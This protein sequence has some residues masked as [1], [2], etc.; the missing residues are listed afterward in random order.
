MDARCTDCGSVLTV[1]VSRD[2]FRPCP[3]CGSTS[4]QFFA[5][6]MDKLHVEDSH[7]MEGRRAGLG[8]RKGWF[9][10]SFTRLVAQVSRGGALAY[11]TRLMDRDANRYVETVAMRDTGEVIHHCDEPLSEHQG[12]GSAR[13]QST[14]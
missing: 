11:H 10:R 7:G 1:E 13:K 12:H 5:E 14:T 8:R 2:P 9:V 6:I 3:V 4:R